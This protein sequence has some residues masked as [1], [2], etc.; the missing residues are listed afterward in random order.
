MIFQKSKYMSIFDYFN[1]DIKKNILNENEYN[2]DHTLLSPVNWR[3]DKE[4]YKKHYTSEQIAYL[5]DH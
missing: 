3:A 5:F 4:N 2:G 1:K